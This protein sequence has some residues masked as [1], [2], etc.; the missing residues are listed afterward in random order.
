MSAKGR[1][2]DIDAIVNIIKS[3][4]RFVHVSVMDYEP[5]IV[6]TPKVKQVHQRTTSTS[7]FVS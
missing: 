3:A 5:L 1:T 4:E 7:I 2:Q 6:F